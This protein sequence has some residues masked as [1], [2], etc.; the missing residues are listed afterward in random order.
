MTTATVV[1]SGPNG[2]A[3]A[4]TLAR[5]GVSVTVLEMADR[6][7]G[8]TRTSELTVP[9]VLHDD[10]SAVHPMGVASAFFRSAGLDRYGL[11]WLRAPIDVVHPLD[12]GRAG[13]LQTSLSDTVEGLGA[14]GA[15]WRRVFGPLVRTFEDLADEFFQPITH[16]PRHLVPMARFGPTALSPAT[17]TASRLQ[18]PEARALFGGVA[19]HAVYPLSRP[20]TSAIGAMM[21]AA[22]HNHG[23]PVAEGGSEAITTAMAKLLAELGG[24]VHTGVE[25]THL[26]EVT[27]DIV[28]MDL[29][30][31]AVVDLAGHRL[32]ARVAKAY[33]RYRYGPAAFKLD[34]AVDDHI[35]WTN[36]AARYAGTVHVC[37]SFEEIVAA[38]RDVHR[39]VMPQR[40]YVLLA[41]QYLAD[42]SRSAGSIHPIWAYAHT[43]HGYTGDATGLILDQIERF[44]PGFRERIAAI[45]SRSPREMPS[46]NPN[47]VGGDIIT[48]LNSPRQVLMRPRVAFDPYATGIDGVYI[49]SAATPP[50]GGVHG[51]NGHNAAL[52][53]LRHVAR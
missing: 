4:V 19:A 32:P 5:A 46:Y 6:I 52:S 38:E 20:T 28:M 45:H 27:S 43:P 21:I 8:G 31:T 47:Y 13:V 35:P 18:T 42:P 51:M 12:G 44:A 9:G 33:R 17:L 39:G 1:G 14:D 3:A 53:A 2:L 40:P 50:G 29:S 34:I 22:G 25:V 23:W 11:R 26:D 41:Q 37:G 10:C 24:T 7:G 36:E 15:R 48:G 30:P 49:C 16:I